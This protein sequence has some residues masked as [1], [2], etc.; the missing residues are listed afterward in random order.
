M[1]YDFYDDDLW[2]YK[3]QCFSSESSDV[4]VKALSKCGYDNARIFKIMEN[5]IR[6]TTNYN[7]YLDGL[8]Y[9]LNVDNREYMRY[10]S[11][12]VSKKCT[13]EYVE[14]DASWVVDVLNGKEI[15]FDTL[16]GVERFLLEENILTVEWVGDGDAP[17]F[18]DNRIVVE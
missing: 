18:I 12:P 15:W 14:E 4:I 17:E 2:D 9:A 8:Y 16:K 11:K 3:D 7:N 6:S 13:L 1:K 5:F 10:D